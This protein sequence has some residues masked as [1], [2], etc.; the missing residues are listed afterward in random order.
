MPQPHDPNSASSKSRVTLTVING[1]PRLW[2]VSETHLPK[3]SRWNQTR[4]STQP[5]TRWRAATPVQVHRPDY[6]IFPRPLATKVPCLGIE[7]FCLP[8]PL[9][10]CCLVRMPRCR[11]ASKACQKGADRNLTRAV[12]VAGRNA[13]GSGKLAETSA[14]RLGIASP[15]A[16]ASRIIFAQTADGHG[17]GALMQD[18]FGDSP[19]IISGRMGPAHALGDVAEFSSIACSSQLHI[20][21]R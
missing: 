13:R 21:D 17:A 18:N 1:R 7:H 15:F 8:A 11:S 9:A 5:A 16:G 20:L 6:P 4:T 19:S 3:A 10:P 14:Q 12:P 2:P